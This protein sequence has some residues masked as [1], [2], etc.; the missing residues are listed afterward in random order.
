M[1]VFLIIL[2]IAASLSM[3]STLVCGLWIKANKVT[4]VSS[5]NFHMNIGILSAVLTTAM[6]VAMIVLTVKKL[7]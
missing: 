5:L 3:L 7:A 4:E 1:K 6:A 2:G